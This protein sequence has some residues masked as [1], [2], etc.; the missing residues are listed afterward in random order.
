ML[1]AGVVLVEARGVLLRGEVRLE[2]NFNFAQVFVIKILCAQQRLPA[3]DG[4]QVRR[5]DVALTTQLLAVVRGLQLLPLQLQLAA[6]ALVQ[7]RNGLAQRLRPLPHAL[8]VVRLGVKAVEQGGKA[9]ARL[10]AQI[11]AVLPDVAIGE[12]RRCAVLPQQHGLHLYGRQGGELCRQECR[13]PRGVQRGDGRVRLARKA[14]RQ[15]ARDER[16]QARKVG[17][18]PFVQPHGRVGPVEQGKK[19]GLRRLLR[20]AAVL[21]RRLVIE[22]AGQQLA[23]LGHF[24]VHAAQTVENAAVRPREDQ[25]GIAPDQLEDQVL[26]AGHTQLVRAVE[27]QVEHAL[28]RG[29]ADTG[30]PAAR[31]MLAQQHAE[32]RRLRGVFQLRL[33][34]VD[35]R[36]V[37]V[38]GQQQSSTAVA[39]AQ[40]EHDGVARG[41]LDLVYA[42]PD[43]GGAQLCGDG[44][45]KHGV[46]WHG[47]P[48]SW[49]QTAPRCARSARR[50]TARQT[51]PPA[52]LRGHIRP[53]W[54][55][56]ECREDGRCGRGDR[57]RPPP[58]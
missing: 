38:G 35:A 22:Q 29:L 50:D 32:H 44:R 54:R 39:P 5:D 58:A 41:L 56:S 6:R 3:C 20:D 43:K 16:R 40:L 31:Q 55:A 11:A 26:A 27:R 14:E 49:R 53:V 52:P 1:G 12:I 47:L 17:Q 34:Q 10:G 19:L 51:G 37:A 9:L 23:Q 24:K 25:V 13:Q 21:P 36:P 18:Q 7:V 4:V 48:P 28:G 2:R 33:R 15:L 8:G 30:K 45:E 42:G 57:R 46:K